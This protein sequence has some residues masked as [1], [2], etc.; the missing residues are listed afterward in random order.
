MP[1]QT[2]RERLIELLESSSVLKASAIVNHGIDRKTVQRMVQTGEIQRIGRG[3]YS[4]SDYEVDSYHSYVEAQLLVETGVICLLSALSFHAI[5]TQ[6]PRYVWLAVSRPSRIP[7]IEGLPVKIVTFSEPAFSAG[8]EEHQIEG[9]TVKVYSPA[10]T[11]A[12][13]FKFRNKLGTDVAIEALRE[14]VREKNVS[15]DELLRFADICRVRSVL[16]PY[17]EGVMQ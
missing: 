14:A 16:V 8:I 9:A 10:K 6:T 15:P 5:G 3:L 4:L 1:N 17:L 12:D 11:V 2:Q 7:K 13:C